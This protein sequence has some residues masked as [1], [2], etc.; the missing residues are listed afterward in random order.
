LTSSGGST[1]SAEPP[2]GDNESRDRRTIRERTVRI[3][4]SVR[5]FAPRPCSDLD[6]PLAQSF[7][8]RLDAVRHLELLVDV[9]EVRADGG[10]GKI[11]DVRRFAV[12]EALADEAEDL[13]LPLGERPRG[14]FLPER[15]RSRRG[16]RGIL[17]HV[18]VAQEAPGAARLD[19]ASPGVDLAG[20]LDL[21]A[22]RG[23]PDRL[24]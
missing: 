13:D 23:P 19:D 2:E 15:R 10:A 6:D 20:G 11:E 16:R 1:E 24:P 22:G 18:E 7:G 3:A 17:G 21:L 8:H 9:L 14:R 5:R 12:G 4:V